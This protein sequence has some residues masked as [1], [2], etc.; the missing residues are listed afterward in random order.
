MRKNTKRICAL[1]FAVIM[2]VVTSVTPVFAATSDLTSET[3][4]VPRASQNGFSFIGNNPSL[5]VNLSRD[6]VAY[7]TTKT[8]QILKTGSD[9]NVTL[10]FKNT[11][12]NKSYYLAF[13]ADGDY[14]AREGIGVTVPAGTYNVTIEVNS[15][16]ILQMTCTFNF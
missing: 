10:K 4:V 14:H 8:Y 16:N 9:C 15:C 1:L 6:I 5:T 7:S 11:S 13:D 12:T 2:C 3:V